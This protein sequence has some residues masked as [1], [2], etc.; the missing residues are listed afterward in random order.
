MSGEVAR[1]VVEANNPLTKV[2]RTTNSPPVNARCWSF[3]SQ[4]M[5]D[6]LIADKL[7]ISMRT[8]RFHL[9]HIYAKLHVRSRMEAALKRKQVASAPR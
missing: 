4:G 1:K 8:V 3:L 2:N 7:S 9:G 5:A 6:K